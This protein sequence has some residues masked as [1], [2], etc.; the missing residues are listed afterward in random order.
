M[1]SATVFLHDVFGVYDDY[2]RLMM[3]INFNSDL[4]DGWEHAAES[5]YPRERSD[6]AFK[7]GINTVV[8][9]ID[10][11]RLTLFWSKRIM[12]IILFLTLIIMLSVSTGALD[13][14]DD[15]DSIH[16]RPIKI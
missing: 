8:L 9:F 15:S 6:M 12:R 13:G 5:F 3:M 10:A 1:K 11:L 14:E 2:G 4:G 16:L 7:L